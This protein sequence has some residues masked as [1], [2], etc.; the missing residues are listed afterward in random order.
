MFPERERA[1]RELSE[2]AEERLR[3]YNPL[4]KF[5]DPAIAEAKE[6]LER[7]DMTQF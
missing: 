1:I 2:R 6:K 7:N 4:S 5:V 3:R